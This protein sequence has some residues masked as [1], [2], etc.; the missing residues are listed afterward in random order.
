MGIAP[1]GNEVTFMG[2]SHARIADG[3]IAECWEI[4]DIAGLMAQIGADGS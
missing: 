4:M 2:V 1:T 3:K